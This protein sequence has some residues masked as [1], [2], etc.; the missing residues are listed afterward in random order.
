MS[1]R[2]PIIIAIPLDD[3]RLLFSPTFTDLVND[4]G[5]KEVLFVGNTFKPAYFLLEDDVA[6]RLKVGPYKDLGQQDTSMLDDN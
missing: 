4:F 3:P 6:Y 2:V 5:E 1:T